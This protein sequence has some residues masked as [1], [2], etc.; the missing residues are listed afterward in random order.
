MDPAKSRLLIAEMYLLD[1]GAD[2]EAAWFDMT[3]MTPSGRE[4]TKSDWI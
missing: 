2:I 1:Q 4:R 3:M